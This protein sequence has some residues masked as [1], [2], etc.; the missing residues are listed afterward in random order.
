MSR[1]IKDSKLDTREA[2]TRLKVQGKPYWR[3]IEPGLH[4]GYRKLRGRPGTWCVRRYVGAQT[5]EVER[6]TGVIA[7]D[8]SEAD[9]LTVLGFAQAQQRAL[10][11]KPKAGPFTVRGAVEDYLR[12]IEHKSGTYDAGHRAKA[13]I[14]PALGEL[15][16][17]ELTTARLRQWHVD[18]ADAPRRCRTRKGKQQQY[19]KLDRSEE[20]RRRRRSSANRVLTTLK[21]ALNHAWRE[22]RAASDAE[23]RR[24][25]PFPGTVRARARYLTIEECRRLVNASDGDF[26]PLVQAALATGCRYG[27]LTRLVAS[28]FNATAGTVHV[29]LS[30]SGKPRHVVVADEGIALFKRLCAGRTADELLFRAPGGGPW[31]RSCQD[32]PMQLTCERARIRPAASFHILRHTWASLSV[33]AGMP[34][35]IVARNLGH[36]STKM[37]EAHYGHLAPSYIA[38]QVRENAPRFGFKPDKKIAALRG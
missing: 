17:E 7:D 2:R 6:L 10:V 24:V 8:N 38:E 21:A 23:W 33:M 11:K 20:G 34:L 15:K 3:L 5:Y 25:K 31:T 26:R 32:R 4:L 14:F 13:F 35:L 12:H 37:V 19:L 29:R 22:G 18:M 30:K 1:T 36:A 9:G 27:E 28:D 16:V